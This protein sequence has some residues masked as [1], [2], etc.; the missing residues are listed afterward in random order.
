M[1]KLRVLQ[2]LILGCLHNGMNNRDW[3]N[4]LTTAILFAM[5]IVCLASC[6]VHYQLPINISDTRHD[7]IR[8]EYV[9]DSIYVERDRTTY[10]LGDTVYRID[11]VT[12]YKEQRVVVHDSIMINRTDTIY[13]IPHSTPETELPRGTQF[14]RNSGIALWVIL[15]VLFIA[16]IAGIIFKLAK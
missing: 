2:P 8:R 12:L 13:Q 5:L 14:L 11:S 15:S 10:I 7:S 16:I 6:K 1:K 9:H 4:I 3:L